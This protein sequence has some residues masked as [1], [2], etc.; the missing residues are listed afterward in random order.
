MPIDQPVRIRSIRVPTQP[1]RYEIL[2]LGQTGE[3]LAQ[4]VS[5]D[6]DLTFR[7]EPISG[8]WGEDGTWGGDAGR[9]GGPFVGRL[10]IRG[11]GRVDVAVGVNGELHDAIRV[12]RETVEPGGQVE[13]LGAGFDSHISNH[14]GVSK[15]EIGDLQPGYLCTLPPLLESTGS[16]RHIVQLLLQLVALPSLAGRTRPASK[17]P[18]R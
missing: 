11:V 4:L 5:Q 1:G 17:L 12:G 16:W 14:H 7:D 15:Y 18:R 13:G 6:L 9:L 8:S 10:G 3:D 2:F